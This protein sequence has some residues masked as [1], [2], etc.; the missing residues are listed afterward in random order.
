MVNSFIARAALVA[1]LGVVASTLVATP[2]VAGCSSDLKIP[3]QATSA[4]VA[5]LQTCG[6]PTGLPLSFGQRGSMSIEIPEKGNTTSL[7]LTYLPGA[8]G[9]D[10]ASVSRFD[11]GSIGFHS[12]QDGVKTFGGDSKGLTQVRAAQDAAAPLSTLATKCTSSSYV[13]EGFWQINS[14]DYYVN[15]SSFAAGAQARIDAAANTVSG[16]SDS[17]GLSGTTGIS[18]SDLGSTTTGVNMTAALSCGTSDGKSVHKMGS[19]TVG[20]VAAA[21]CVWSNGLGWVLNADTLYKN[22]LSWWTSSMTTG[23]FGMYDLQNVA[24]HEIGHAFGLDHP[25]DSTQVMY[26]SAA[27]CDFGKRLL[28]SG[29]HAGLMAIY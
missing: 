6:D 22:T 18:K 10:G 21:T 29:D 2:A 1:T 4:N 5:A 14:Y 25:A 24:T 8:T 19:V 28:G 23:C 13:K 15:T 27:L 3:V 20:A 12:S 26:A 9:I 16:A 17:C 7:Y 11:D